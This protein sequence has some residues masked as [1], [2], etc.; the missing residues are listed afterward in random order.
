MLDII[1]RSLNLVLCLVGM[2]YVFRLRRT[3]KGRF[4]IILGLVLFAFTTTN[5]FAIGY[6]F[7][8]NPI[9]HLLISYPSMVIPMLLIMDILLRVQAME[10]DRLVQRE[11]QSSILQTITARIN[12]TLDVRQI[13]KPTLEEMLQILE[14]DG[15]ALYLASKRSDYL[16]LLWKEGLFQQTQVDL[17]VVAAKEIFSVFSMTENGLVYTRDIS[18]DQEFQ[19]CD[20]LKAAG[21][22]TVVAVQLRS[23]KEFIGV[24]ILAN[25]QEVSIGFEQ[26]RSIGEI[27][28]WLSVA[29]RNARLWE[30]LRKAY[31][32]I[33]ISFSRAV[34]AKDP[35]TSGHSDNVARLSVELASYLG[36]SKLEIEKA[37]IG[38]RLHDIGKIGIPEST[39]NKTGTLTKDEYKLIKEHAYKGYEIT[40]PIDS[41]IKISDIIL[42]HHERYDG[43]GYPLGLSGE[44]IPFLARIIAIAD[45]FDAMTSDRPYRKGIPYKDALEVI[46]QNKG[47]QFDPVLATRF[48]EMMKDN[49][50]DD[51][52]D[53]EQK[54]IPTITA[55][56]LMSLLSDMLSSDFEAS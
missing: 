29:I 10:G 33:V 25:E 2:Y 50:D 5:E 26:M 24:I 28:S 37:Y 51:K 45:A 30:D 20:K 35:Y 4:R 52:A 1:F 16:E 39:L 12:D 36:L 31:L 56:E 53:V 34:E 40:Q 32:K 54:D 6:T 22:K 38:A 41:M 23:Q 44:Q 21:V 17:S 15:A 9:Y 7:T 46:E 47:T 48:V 27:A 55:D 14:F 3:E 11:R 49:I 18:C 8:G 43:K 42:H 19:I 13:V